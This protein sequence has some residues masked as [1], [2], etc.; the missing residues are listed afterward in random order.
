MYALAFIA[1]INARVG[2]KLAMRHPV[3]KFARAKLPPSSTRSFDIAEGAPSSPLGYEYMSLKKEILKPRRLS[4]S[5]TIP[6]WVRGKLYR[7]GPALFDIGGD[8]ANHWFDGQA[9]IHCFDFHGSDSEETEVGYSNRF[10]DTTNLRAHR[11]AGKF[12]VPEFGT[13]PYWRG[14]M[15]ERLSSSLR[16]LSGITAGNRSAAGKAWQKAG[17]NQNANV[18]VHLLSGRLVALTELPVA[19]EFDETLDT[20]GPIEWNDT[21]EGVMSTAHPL[22][23]EDGRS[24]NLL[25]VIG[26]QCQYI[27][28]TTPNEKVTN[29]KRTRVATIDTEKASYMHSFGA[30]KNWYVLAETPWKFSVSRALGQLTWKALHAMN[31]LVIG[32]TPE[33]SDV[34][35]WTGDVAPATWILV[36]RATGDIVRI[37][38]PSFFTLHFVNCFELDNGTVAVDVMC[39]ER[40]GYS[41]L[42]LQ[43]L[44]AGVKA[45]IPGGQ[46]R[47]YFLNPDTKEWSF[48]VLEDGIC[49]MPCID[50]RY[51]SRHRYIYGVGEHY[52][53]IVRVDAE[54]PGRGRRAWSALNCSCGEPIFVPQPGGREGDGVLLS[55]VFD[56]AAQASFLLVLDAGRMKELARLPLPFCIPKMIHGLFVP[57]DGEE[58]TVNADPSTPAEPRVPVNA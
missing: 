58:I 25:T 38:V 47:R 36:N 5:G 7:N 55:V 15:A 20:V 53:S 46:V 29:V 17:E 33:P 42:S 28:Y 13:D 10:L 30:T 9:M 31:S 43:K 41:P 4:K 45:D 56:A 37:N 35:K 14:T 2:I 51:S 8:T 57:D 23:L 34:F 12:A 50:E 16:W 49:E 40:A 21:E 1:A 24:L 39:Y 19:M 26:S 22:K 48:E 3:A 32:E 44:R 27:L 6:A 18:N 52:E 11:A 54:K